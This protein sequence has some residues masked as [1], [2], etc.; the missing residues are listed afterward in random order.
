MTGP[1][2]DPSDMS[3]NQA[4]MF[5]VHSF[6]V[7]QSQADCEDHVK[8]NVP[9]HAVDTSVN[10]SFVDSAPNLPFKLFGLEHLFHHRT[11]V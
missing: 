1:G 2:I 6:N 10:Q 9:I 3:N 4:S 5:G 8:V 7:Q 11:T